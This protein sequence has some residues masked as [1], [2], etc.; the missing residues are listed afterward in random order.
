MKAAFFKIGLVVILALPLFGNASDTSIRLVGVSVTEFVAFVNEWDSFK[1]ALVLY[2]KQEKEFF[3]G[4]DIDN[5]SVDSIK[6]LRH[7]ELDMA[8]K[9]LSD[10]EFGLLKSQLLRGEVKLMGIGTADPC[11]H[12][13]R[14]WIFV[15][16]GGRFKVIMGLIIV[17]ESKGQSRMAL[18]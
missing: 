14:S 3:D 15:V 10:K 1:E 6:G 8:S 2:M 18:T 13:H 17:S 16:S 5:V 9:I 4:C 7:Y 11:G 12:D